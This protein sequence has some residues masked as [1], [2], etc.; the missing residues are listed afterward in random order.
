M[1]QR[2]PD[3]D[4]LRKRQGPSWDEPSREVIARR[5]AV[6]RDGD[7]FTPAQRRTLQ[8]LCERV[9]PQPADRPPVPVAALVQLKVR[10]RHGD[11][12]RD[13]R[14]PPLPQA[15]AIGLDAL[16]AEARAACGRAFADLDDAAQDALI[17]AM[18]RDELHSP[19]WHSMPAAIFFS[20]RV[21]HDISA[22]YYSHPTAWNELGFGGPA[23]PRGYVRLAENTRD[24]WDPAE[25]HPGQERQASE[26][27]RHVR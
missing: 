1:S 7:C 11:G 21:V 25:A 2:Y 20:H 24:S 23:N 9:V 27:N 5:L 15:W 10:D 18:Q 17:A 12:Y 4:V 8:A 3:Y 14:L 22:A 16:D 26:L 13:A 6:R 19:A